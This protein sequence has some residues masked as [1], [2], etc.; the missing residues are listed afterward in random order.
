MLKLQVPK[1]LFFF[2]LYLAVTNCVA[3]AY[4]PAANSKA[5]VTSGKARFTILTDRVIRMEYA[6]D[7]VFNDLSTITF[8]NRNLPVPVFETK[9]ENG[10]LL[11]TTSYLKLRYTLNSGSFNSKN[12]QIEYHDQARNFTWKPGLNDKQNLKGTTRTLDGT[13]GTFS[14]QT[15]KK[16]KL[17]DGVI[18]RSGWAL[19]DDSQKPN[20]DNSDWPWVQNNGTPH[21]TDW[22]F[23]GYGNNYKSA[24]LDYTHISG[25]ISLPPKFAFGVW[26]SKY[27]Q[28]TEQDF[29]NI[30][31]GY[32]THGIP[33][34][35]LVI[36]MDWHQTQSSDPEAFAKYKPTP[37]GW[38]GFTWSKKYFPDYAGF[39]KWTND[40]NIQ[41]CLNLHPASGVQAHEAT[42][43]QFANAIGFDTT[44]CQPIKFDITNKQFAKNYFDVLLHPYEKAG[45]DFWWLDW[46]QYSNT[47]IKGVNPTFYLNYLS[48]TGMAGW[49]INVIKLVLAAM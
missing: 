25:K 28:Y 11:I 6:P 18:S 42:Y 1:C 36:D 27:S 44:G 41:T 3:Q 10:I 20:F 21:N 13:S 33:L 30:V 24:L 47:G 14:Y 19:V 2:M 5:I 26:Y 29:K 22:Y 49:V 17:D 35:V 7:S 38:T 45:V 39:L 46:Q 12:L 16:I 9:N 15:I 32:E 48:S 31:A 4:T 34:D 23:F 43:C 40:K 8:Q 37:D